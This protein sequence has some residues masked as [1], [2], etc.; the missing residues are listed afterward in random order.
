MLLTST[1]ATAASAAPPDSSSLAGLP[2]VRIVFHRNNIFNTAEPGWGQ[3]HLDAQRPFGIERHSIEADP[4]FRNPAN[5]DFHLPPD[6]PAIALGFQP[7]DTSK[8]G[9]RSP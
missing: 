2:I 5:D 7:I 9:P 4:R 1:R 3:K 6:S 8:A